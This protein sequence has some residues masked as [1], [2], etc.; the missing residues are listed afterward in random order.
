MLSRS[1]RGVVEESRHLPPPPPLFSRSTPLL[2]PARSLALGGTLSCTAAA[3]PAARSVAAA[4]RRSTA[5]LPRPERPVSSASPASPRA[6]PPRSRARSLSS[7]QESDRPRRSVC[8]APAHTPPLGRTAPS[9]CS[10]DLI[11]LAPLQLSWL[12]AAAVSVFSQ[13]DQTHT[14]TRADPGLL[15]QPVAHLS[16]PPSCPP[17]QLP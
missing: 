3:F 2:L 7:E 10:L 5:S 14:A 1:K 9:L 15:P 11:A 6:Q 8:S 12:R 17:A 4:S 13:P 16:S